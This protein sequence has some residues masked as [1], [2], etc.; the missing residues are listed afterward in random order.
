MLTH[1]L[2]QHLP[3]VEPMQRQETARWIVARQ[4]GSIAQTDAYAAVDEVFRL[5]ADPAH[6]ELFGPS[7]RAEIRVAGNVMIRGTEV[8]VS[9][10]IDRIAVSKGKVVIADFKTNRDV[11]AEAAVAPP[12]YILQLALYREL[13]RQIYPGR[14]VHCFLLWTRYGR[15]MRVDDAM[16]DRALAEITLS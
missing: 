16:M 8:A 11:P 13:L 6:A 12:A 7:S 9:G 5:L 14:E 10:Q 1:L 4:A 2:L 15:L 3:A